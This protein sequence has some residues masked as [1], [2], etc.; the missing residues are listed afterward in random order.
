MIAGEPDLLVAPEAALIAARLGGQTMMERAPEATQFAAQ[1][2]LRVWGSD[3]APFSTGPGI[4]CTQESCRAEIRGQTVLLVRDAG[5]IDCRVA[6]I[7]SAAW[8][9]DPCVATPVFDHAAVLRDGAVAIRL[10][11]QGPAVMS[12]R[13]VRGSRPWVVRDQPVLPMAPAE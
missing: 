8:L 7:V 9:H 12:D 5:A 2:P 1:A 10:T 4:R 11:P 3:A 13:L 6:V